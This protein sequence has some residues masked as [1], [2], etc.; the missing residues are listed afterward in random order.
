MVLLGTSLKEY[1]YYLSSF[2]FFFLGT[3]LDGGLLGGGGGERG[4]GG[5]EGRNL[6][7]D[8]RTLTSE[9]QVWIR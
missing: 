9:V 2:F 8:P 5:V 1:E 3:P 6:I 4:G 7:S